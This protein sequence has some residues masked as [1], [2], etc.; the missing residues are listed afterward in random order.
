MVRKVI[1]VGVK[2][3]SWNMIGKGVC[4]SLGLVLLSFVGGEVVLLSSSSSRIP[5]IDSKAANCHDE[6]AVAVAVEEEV[7]DVKLPRPRHIQFV[8]FL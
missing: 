5:R 6:F 8:M 3:G 2:M 7:V 4:F 1:S